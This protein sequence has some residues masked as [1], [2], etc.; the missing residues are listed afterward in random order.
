MIGD[1]IRSIIDLLMLRRTEKKLDAEIKKAPSD[2]PKAERDVGKA[3][4]E[5]AKR[6]REKAPAGDIVTPE[7]IDDIHK[8]DLRAGT[9]AAQ[10]KQLSAY[11]SFAHSDAD[12]AQ[13]LNTTLQQR[14]GLSAFIKDD[15]QGASAYL[16]RVIP[17]AI[18]A[19]DIFIVLLS[20]ATMKSNYLGREL[21]LAF[22]MN[23]RVVPVYVEAFDLEAR[24]PEPFDQLRSISA[25]HL[26]E[27][28]IEEA[29]EDIARLMRGE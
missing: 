6:G 18:E 15:R 24:W 14:H 3:R 22:Q 29:A 9:I 28:S 20:P 8:D 5:I 16:D 19:A 17:R 21:Q 11:V 7:P 12:F 13:S 27:M 1:S 4:S 23:K 2:F 25:L 10:A 26:E